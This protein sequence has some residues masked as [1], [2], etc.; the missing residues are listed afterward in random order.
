MAQFAAQTLSSRVGRTVVDKTGLTGLFDIH[1][2]FSRDAAP[3]GLAASS[4]LEAVPTA[5]SPGIVQALEQQLGL[6]LTS[7]RIPVEII[8]IDREERPTENRYEEA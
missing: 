7:T 8:V 6:K 2:E 1:M 3:G 5:T 4:A